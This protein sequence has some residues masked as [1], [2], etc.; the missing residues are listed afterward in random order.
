[1]EVSFFSFG[2][3]NGT[4]NSTILPLVYQSCQRE[5]SNFIQHA[6][7]IL[8]LSLSFVASSGHAANIANRSPLTRFASA[9]HLATSSLFD[10][11]SY[12]LNHLFMSFRH[13]NASSPRT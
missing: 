3:V 12:S 4:S 1:M 8:D 10:F 9:R 11:S 13:A 7:A 2:H 6:S 5:M